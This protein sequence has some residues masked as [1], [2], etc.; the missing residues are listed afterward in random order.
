MVN[1]T[2]FWFLTRGYVRRVE[3]PGNTMI[4]RKHRTG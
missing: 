4:D 2:W 1:E 3:I